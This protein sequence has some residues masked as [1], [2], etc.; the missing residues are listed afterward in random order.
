MRLNP[1][2]MKPMVVSRS[3]T[4]A[5]GFSNFTL[6]GAELEEEKGLCIRGV[7]FDSKLTLNS[8]S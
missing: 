3:R 8:I 5:L 1:K 2:K 4:N 7:I 6:S